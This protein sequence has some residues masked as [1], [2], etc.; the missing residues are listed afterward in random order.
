MD[1]CRWT[2]DPS[3]L[4]TVLQMLPAH[5]H[6]RLAPFPTLL[7]LIELET[8]SPLYWRGEKRGKMDVI[9]AHWL[10]D[11]FTRHWGGAVSA[12][13]GGDNGFHLAVPAFFMARDSVRMSSVWWRCCVL[14]WLLRLHLQPLHRLHIFWRRTVRE[15]ESAA[16]SQRPFKELS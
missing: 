8:F 9:K 14:L 12:R 15:R 6:K 1:N 16:E 4:F 13:R 2:H 3:V 11:V 7:A 5:P 10:W